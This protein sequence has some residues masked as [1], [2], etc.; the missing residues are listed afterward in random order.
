MDILE[1]SWAS[2]AAAM[3]NFDLDSAD[4]SSVGRL[5]EEG[6]AMMAAAFVSAARPTAAKQDSK[7]TDTTSSS[8]SEGKSPAAEEASDCTESK[9]ESKTE[10]KTESKADAEP[11]GTAAK[12]VAVP[13]LDAAAAAWQFMNSAA[14]KS[15]L[16]RVALF[17]DLRQLA[18]SESKAALTS[19]VKKLRTQATKSIPAPARGVL[20]GFKTGLHDIHVLFNV[21]AFGLIPSTLREIALAVNGP[22]S[23]AGVGSAAADTPPAAPVAPP[24]APVDVPE[25]TAVQ[26]T[27]AGASSAAN[28]AGEGGSSATASPAAPSLTLPTVA[29]LAS[30]VRWIVDTL[31]QARA[32]RARMD[33]F[34]ASMEAQRKQA[35][36]LR[37]AREESEERERVEKAANAP[38]EEAAKKEEKKEVET[39]KEEDV[40]AKKAVVGK[41]TEGK[42]TASIVVAKN[43]PSA[44]ASATTTTDTSSTATDETAAE[45]DAASRASKKDMFFAGSKRVIARHPFMP[46]SSP[47][48]A[49]S[50]P[51]VA[52]DEDVEKRP[53]KQKKSDLDSVAP[54][55]AGVAGTDGKQANKG[56]KK[57]LLAEV[58]GE[59]TPSTVGRSTEATVKGTAEGKAEG[60]AAAGS[61]P[62][63]SKPAA[64]AKGKSAAVKKVKTAAKKPAS[65]GSAAKK[66]KTA[67]VK[68]PATPG[69]KSIMSF[70]GRS[71]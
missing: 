35:N 34:R 56:G 69:T 41:T 4:P 1:V 51:N 60:K 53:K 59:S 38:S 6:L 15:L 48:A 67:A 14:S 27:D 61:A 70:F 39:T 49:D 68:K 54:D 33:Q 30:R 50:E 28:V 12:K 42:P 47:L 32:S 46:V 36:L 63:S 55:A 25:A 20:K 31:E 24:T 40:V 52:V 58:D 7:A 13:A 19:S 45:G 21:A 11:T 65:Q 23:A 66:T 62:A 44:A 10:L 57:R 3:P 9:T 26:P 43:P 29:R 2:I 5:Q 8:A 16:A 71:S 18:R 64:K 37:K 17:D 22:G